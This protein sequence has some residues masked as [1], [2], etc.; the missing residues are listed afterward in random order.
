MYLSKYVFENQK[1]VN[2]KDV[3][4][5]DILLSIRVFQKFTVS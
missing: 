4:Q 2:Q 3:L 1:F 5:R